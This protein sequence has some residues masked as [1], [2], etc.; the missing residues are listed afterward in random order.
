LSTA[1]IN[2]KILLA[3]QRSPM[4]EVVAVA[5]RGQSRADDYASRRNIARAYGTYADL[6]DDDSVDAVY[7]SLPSGLHHEWTMRA[8]R[9][10]KHVL[11]EKPYSRWPEEVVEAFTEAHAHGLILS[12]AFMFRYHPQTVRLA[13]LVLDQGVL[14][15]LQLIT[16]SFSWPTQSA[17]DIRLDPGLGGGALLDVGVYP[18]SI[19][20]LLA[21]EPLSVTAQQLTSA[22]GVDGV[23]VATMRFPSAIAHFDCGIQLPD[24]S[25]LE[26]VGELGT[27]TVTDPWHCADPRLTVRLQDGS[28]HHEVT[29]S[30]DSY[31]LELEEFGKAVLGR[32]YV[33]VG[34]EDALGQSR[35]TAALLR[36]AA[37]GKSVPVQHS[38]GGSATE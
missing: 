36:A 6:L 18:V 3:A 16:S 17:G 34:L 27:I 15:D 4:A 14:G 7:V 1:S 13:E 30:A 37:T 5:S 11:C 20:R 9:A 32:E 10:G 29:Q 12:E 2:D 21:G 35:A 31:Q 25:H 23:F 38:R 8:L 19:G 22:T 33:L 28:T 24:R 26:V